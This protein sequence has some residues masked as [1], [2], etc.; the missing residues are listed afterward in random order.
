MTLQ[1]VE[2][3]CDSIF[4][5]G[6]LAVAIGRATNS[7]GLAILN[8][9]EK[10]HVI[11]PRKDVCQFMM[12]PFIPTNDQNNKCCNN[13]VY[14]LPIVLEENHTEPEKEQHEL[15]EEVDDNEIVKILEDLMK[16]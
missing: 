10:K 3:N 4:A 1:N 11:N 9:N 2:V 16:D 14:V 13:K 6:Q 12:K 5:P 15:N 8:F 7:S